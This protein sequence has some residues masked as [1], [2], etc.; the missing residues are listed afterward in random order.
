MC[1]R[2]RSVPNT[3]LISRELTK[4]FNTFSLPVE[5]YYQII[6]FLDIKD[7]LSLRKAINLFL[8]V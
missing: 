1:E 8:R 3:P 6:Y 4:A 7:I 2:N 5:I